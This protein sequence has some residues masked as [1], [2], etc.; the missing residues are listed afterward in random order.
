MLRATLFCPVDSYPLDRRF[1]YWIGLIHWISYPPFEQPAP[2]LLEALR[3]RQSLWN[4]KSGSYINRNIKKKE[5]QEVVE[6]VKE[7]LPGIDFELVKVSTIKL[8]IFYHS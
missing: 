7:D 1:I 2:V 5:Y 6:I 3:D 4:T 8:I